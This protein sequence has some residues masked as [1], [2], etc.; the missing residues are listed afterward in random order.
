MR[1][2]CLRHPADG[3]WGVRALARAVGLRRSA[4]R[5]ELRDLCV[6]GVLVQGPDGRYRPATTGP[7]VAP[8]GEGDPVTPAPGGAGEVTKD[9]RL[10]SWVAAQDP[11]AT[12]TNQD[13]RAG[14]RLDGDPWG[15]RTTASFLSRAARDGLVDRVARGEYRT[16]PPAPIVP[17][18]PAS[19]PPEAWVAMRAARAWLAQHPLGLWWT[20]ADLAAAI[21]GDAE[22]REV[23]TGL[24]EEGVVAQVRDGRFTRPHPAV[25][26]PDPDAGPL[27]WAQYPTV[28]DA[29]NMGVHV[30]EWPPVGEWTTAQIGPL[31]T[32]DVN[33]GFGVVV[34]TPAQVGISLFP[35]AGLWQMEARGVAWRYP[36]RGVARQ[37]CRVRYLGALHGQKY[38]RF[39]IACVRRVAACVPSERAIHEALR[40]ADLDCLGLTTPAGRLAAARALGEATLSDPLA[41]DA[42]W[43][44]DLRN[45]T[46]QVLTHDPDDLCNEVSEWCHSLM[47]ERVL[48]RDQARP[49]ASEASLPW[50]HPIIHAEATHQGG[51]VIALLD[52]AYVPAPPPLTPPPP[53][54]AAPPSASQ[55]H[56]EAG[57]PIPLHLVEAIGISNGA[58][59]VAEDLAT[60]RITCDGREVFPLAWAPT[61][62]LPCGPVDQTRAISN[63]G[64]AVRYYHPAGAPVHEWWRYE[65]TGDTSVFRRCKVEQLV[66]YLQRDA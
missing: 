11:G 48:P 3:P 30:P 6:E 16:L 66:G 21:G 38:R 65:Q 55:R 2:W 1:E 26:L 53:G 47:A 25:A 35:D 20:P 45:L 51:L 40:V 62:G 5:A 60:A 41:A 46:R 42:E 43:F 19:A 49:G 57:D 9:E 18:R 44:R 7:D 15:G 23:L 36:G 10:A 59:A 50:Q 8:P 17:A 14:A 56:V 22:A 39:L 12:W 54:A 61:R 27:Y 29:C 37:A 13:A 4:V 31:D 58:P 34:F 33:E 28:E 24:L 63:F 64:V 32:E 52:P